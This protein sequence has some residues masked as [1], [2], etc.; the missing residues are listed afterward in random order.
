MIIFTILCTL[1]AIALSWTITCGIVWAITACFNLTFSL[2][3][4]TGVWLCLLLLNMSLPR[5]PKH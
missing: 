3:V 4:A 5:T 1:F 2:A